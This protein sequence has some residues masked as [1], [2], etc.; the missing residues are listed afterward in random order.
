VASRFNPE[1]KVVEAIVADTGAGIP[2]EFVDRIFDPFFTT[3]KVGE[4]TGLGLFVS[5][6]IVE[7]CGGHIRFETRTVQE[8]TS[9]SGT[10]F[11]VSLQPEPVVA[12]A[13]NHRN[14]VG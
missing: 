13:T 11:F 9:D 5:Y 7:K 10:T 6:A 3:K 8:N 12:E 14:S 4:G 2:K 1:E